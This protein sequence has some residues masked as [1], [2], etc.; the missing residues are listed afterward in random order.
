MRCKMINTI[1]LI[2]G[3]ITAVTVI[4]TFLKKVYKI[5]SK[6]EKNIGTVSTV[7]EEQFF[8]VKTLLAVCDGLGQ[9]GANG[10]VTKAKEDLQ[11]YIIKH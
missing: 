3:V 8:I 6:M 7:K 4:G 5:I 11:D 1:I 9:L 2:A 10:P